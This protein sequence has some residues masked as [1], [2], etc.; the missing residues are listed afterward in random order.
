MIGADLL[1][2]GVLLGSLFGVVVSHL[3]QL[4]LDAESR[5]PARRIPEGTRIDLGGGL[6]AVLIEGVR[7][8]GSCA[9]LRM[10]DKRGEW[11]GSTWL[12]AD[13]LAAALERQGTALAATSGL[14]KL[15]GSAGGGT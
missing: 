7:G 10:Y 6:C 1:G 13:V 8:D 4:A 14:D 9:L 15:R 5:T 2:L 11:V 12:E 3:V